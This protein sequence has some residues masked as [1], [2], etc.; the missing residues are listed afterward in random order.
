M[1]YLGHDGEPCL[2]G[3]YIQENIT[4]DVEEEWEDEREVG[5]PPHLAKPSDRSYLTVVHTNGVHFCDIQ[6][7]SCNSSAESNLQLMMAGMFPATIK[8]PR[9]MFTFQVLDDFIRDNVECGTTVMNY[10]SKLRRVTSNAFPHLVPVR[11][12]IFQCCRN[13]R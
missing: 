2:N 8:E 7:C 12:S 9:T 13:D 11:G 10:Y 4:G 5:C 1:I 6:F 3:G